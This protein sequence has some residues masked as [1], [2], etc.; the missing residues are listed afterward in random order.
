MYAGKRKFD[1]C[2]LPIHFILYTSFQHCTECTRRYKSMVMVPLHFC[3]S[4]IK[5]CLTASKSFP[6]F[7][8][9]KSVYFILEEWIGL[10]IIYLLSRGTLNLLQL[11]PFQLFFSDN[12]LNLAVA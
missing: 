8:L 12:S 9:E 7:F 10:E 11:F 6:Y 5:L 2:L 4:I 1:G 3:S